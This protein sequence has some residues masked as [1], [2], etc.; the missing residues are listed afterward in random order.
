MNYA[1]IKRFEKK[2]NE[3]LSATN[4]T[5]LGQIVQSD[6]ISAILTIY[7]PSIDET[8]D[9]CYLSAVLPSKFTTQINTPKTLNETFEF[10]YTEND[11]DYY[12]AEF[13][14]DS[15]ITKYIGE[16]KLNIVVL[17]KTGNF[18]SITD[19]TG[20]TREVE[21]VL[22][23][24]SETLT[25]NVAR[26]SNF[27]SFNLSTDEELEEA[28]S[29]ITELIKSL[30]SFP[31]EYINKTNGV[32]VV[33][34]LPASLN[35]YANRILYER[36][37]KQIYYINEEG[38]AEPNFLHRSD[39]TANDLTINNAILKETLTI[40]ID[41]GS[42][43]GTITIPSEEIFQINGD[44][45]VDEPVHDN[46]PATK[47][48]IDDFKNIVYENAGSN[49]IIDVDNIT[50]E[51]YY[52]KLQNLDFTKRKPVVQLKKLEADLQHHYY[53]CSRFN[54]TGTIITCEVV[55]VYYSTNGISVQVN[56][57]T[58][59]QPST[60][61]TYYEGEVTPIYSSTKIDTITS[62][63][64]SYIDTKISD[65]VGST[66]EE[67]DTLQEIV[68]A[69]QNADKDFAQA[70]NELTQNKVDKSLYDED[71][72]Y[73]KSHAGAIISFDTENE[74]LI[75]EPAPDT[76]EVTQ[77]LNGSYG[78]DESEG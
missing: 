5:S 71:I 17:H 68:E 24:V 66:P 47:K 41:S 12:K 51:N 60:L 67:L 54:A 2:F 76:L 38:V 73:L 1:L 14:I 25:L 3:N 18:Y 45:I 75:I 52:L 28:N 31:S 39:D 11:L 10:A 53:T 59:S 62:S 43:K 77:L 56:K 8:K 70:I 78:T 27:Y 13:R 50:S 74:T 65:I 20:E 33:D 6:N 4:G 58:L 61:N 21:N 30:S 35:S 29:L 37:T 64:Q 46:N 9:T 7:I 48:Y 19:D 69:F 55:K 34:T 22:T 44:L 57:A 72:N 15:R 40:E 36:S 26:S 49:L 63:L 16:V 32:L 23:K 42:L